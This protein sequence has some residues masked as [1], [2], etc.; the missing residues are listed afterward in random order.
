MLQFYQQSVTIA[1]QKGRIIV[2]QI[3]L[4]INLTENY[5]A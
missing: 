1:R 3:N 5:S 2:A 4:R